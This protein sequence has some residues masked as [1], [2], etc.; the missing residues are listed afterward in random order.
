MVRPYEGHTM[1][2]AR[3]VVLGASFALSPRPP[4]LLGRDIRTFDTRREE[5]LR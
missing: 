5:L 3:P 2:F 4:D 1:T